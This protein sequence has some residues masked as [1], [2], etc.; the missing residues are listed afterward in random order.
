MSTPADAIPLGRREFEAA[1]SELRR[2]EDARADN[3]GSYK[4][5]DC[6]RCFDCMFTTASRDCFA[7]TYCQRCE[8]CSD[9][10]HC[11]DC[12]NCH[13]SSYCQRSSNCYKS[14]Y[15]LLSHNCYACLFCFGCVGLSKKEFHILNMPFKRKV[16][17]ELVEQLKQTLGLAR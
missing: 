14:S 16:Y 5:D 12:S 10:T 9:C 7:C 4:S 2:R 8:D 15:V 13:A 6:T 17:F 11:A 3:P 1:L